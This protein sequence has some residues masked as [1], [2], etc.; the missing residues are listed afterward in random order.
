MNQ[1]ENYGGVHAKR[2]RR[3]TDLNVNLLCGISQNRYGVTGRI[4]AA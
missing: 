3:A 4:M 2:G 1:I